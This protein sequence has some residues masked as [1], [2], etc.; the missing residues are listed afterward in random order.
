VP[1]DGCVHIGPFNANAVAIIRD[2]Y[3]R[4]ALE[5]IGPITFRTND[6]ANRIPVKCISTFATLEELIGNMLARSEFVQIIVCHGNHEDGLLLPFSRGARADPGSGRVPNASGRIMSSLGELAK[7]GKLLA[8]DDPNFKGRIQG[9]ADAMRV[10]KED[11]VRV[12][13][14]LGRFQRRAC[15]VEIRGCNLGRPGLITDLLPEYRAAFAHMTTAPTCRMFYQRFTPRQPPLQARSRT[16]RT[17]EELRDVPTQGNRTRRRLFPAKG[18][19]EPILIEIRDIDGH[20]QVD[21]AS[22]MNDPQNAIHWAVAFLTNWQ[23]T[24]GNNFVVP[25]MWDDNETTFHFPK[26]P[27]YC[28]KLRMIP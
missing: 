17:L 21:N 10:T 2:Y 12:A 22:F 26:E 4:C 7:Q 5:T 28:G 11:V 3:T 8:V 24:A 1:S 15:I 14:M 25:V 16:R 19:P 6:I 13:E 18:A 9:I 23:M 20:A 27:G